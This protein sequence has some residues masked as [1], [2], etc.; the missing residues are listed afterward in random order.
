MAGERGYLDSVDCCGRARIAIPLQYRRTDDDKTKF[1]RATKPIGQP[2]DLTAGLATLE[3]PK[4]ASHRISKTSCDGT[5]R[6]RQGEKSCLPYR[7][8]AHLPRMF[9]STP[10]NGVGGN[11]RTHPL[12]R[13][14]HIISAAP[15]K[16]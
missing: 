11:G 10:F 3:M 13:S 9:T 4:I 5:G 6:H 7:C 12:G 14:L 1:R 2:I 15:A 16:I 8:T